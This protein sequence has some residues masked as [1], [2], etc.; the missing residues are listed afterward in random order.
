MVSEKLIDAHFNDST[1]FRL[2]TLNR[3]F[4]TPKMKPIRLMIS[5]HPK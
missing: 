3:V 1:V 4:V 2:V 5:L